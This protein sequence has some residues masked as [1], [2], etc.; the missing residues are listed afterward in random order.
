MCAVTKAHYLELIQGRGVVFIL[1]Y[2][3][4]S[5]VSTNLN[6]QKSLGL[7]KQVQFIFC[8]KQRT[9]LTDWSYQMSGLKIEKSQKFYVYLN[10]NDENILSTLAILTFK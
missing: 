6:A 3:I 8:A 4:V 2:S 9:P 7:D 5:E 10:L 1:S